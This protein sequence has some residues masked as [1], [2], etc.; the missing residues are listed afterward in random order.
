MM[1]QLV[2]FALQVFGVIAL[3]IGFA[4]YMMVV[5]FL[6]GVVGRILSLFFDLIFFSAPPPSCSP[7]SFTLPT[8]RR[9]LSGFASMDATAREI[10]QRASDS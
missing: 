5:A 9:A 8:P 3:L 7:P 10:Q 4:V 2:D 1:S 6:F